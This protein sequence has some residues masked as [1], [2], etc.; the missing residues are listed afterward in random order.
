MAPQRPQFEKRRRFYKVVDVAPEP[1]GGFGVRLDGRTPRSPAGAPLV[2]PTEALARLLAG[3]WEAQGPEI[4]PAGMP[5]TRLAWA[6]LA[7]GAREAAVERVVAFAGADL[8][9]YFADGPA[10]LVERQERRWGPVL[11]WAADELGA[12]LLRSQGVIHR[13]QPPATLARIEALARAECDFALAGLDVAAALFGS[14]IL[15]LALRFARLSADAAFGLSRLDETF[16]EERWGLDA[17]AAA[18]ADAMAREAVALERWFA[19]LPPPPLAGDP[20][21]KH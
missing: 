15:A 1:G 12:A 7:E 8:L 10:A 13:P 14:T 19:A 3:E 18:R 9:C 6:A 5:A 17:E 11:D 21:R 2:L 20:E 16:Q 4:D